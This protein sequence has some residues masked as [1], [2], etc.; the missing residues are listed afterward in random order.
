MISFLAN[1]NHFC[2]CCIAK[3]A[4]L[5]I[6]QVSSDTAKARKVAAGLEL[7]IRISRIAYTTAAIIF[8]FISFGSHLNRPFQCHYSAP[9]V[10]RE[11]LKLS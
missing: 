11:L 3:E 5:A 1:L 10:I 9:Q 7:C 2:D 8:I 4:S 6:Q